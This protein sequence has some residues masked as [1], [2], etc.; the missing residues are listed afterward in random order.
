MNNMNNFRLYI[1]YEY[2]VGLYILI[3]AH[4]KKNKI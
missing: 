2:I 4:C 3:I 1:T